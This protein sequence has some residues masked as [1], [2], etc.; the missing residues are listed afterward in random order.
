[1]DNP[2]P[3]SRR[4][5]LKYL[6]AAGAAL[7]L[8]NT[9][10]SETKKMPNILFIITDQHTADVMSC[11]G[12]TDVSTPAIDSLAEHGVRFTRAYVTHPLCIPS[13]AS[14]MTGKM[15]SQCRDNV[16][17]HSTLGTHMKRAGYDTGYFGKWHIQP[18]RETRNNDE[19]HGFDTIDTRGLDPV[20]TENSIAFIKQER[21]Q[22]FFM[23]SSFMNPHDI[24]EWARIHSGREDEMENGDI[25]PAPAP[26]QCPTLPTNFNPPDNEPEM[27]R[28]RLVNNERAR[29]F[30]HPTGDW[31]EDDWRQYR[32][33]YCRLVELVDREVGKLLN[34]LKE[35]GQLEDTLIIYSSDHGDGN[36][37][38]GWNQK[39]VLYEEAVRVPFIVSWKG[40]T[41]AGISS[42]ALVSMNLDLL[43]TCCDFADIKLE[44]ALQGR[45]V[46]DQ[47]M[48][49]SQSAQGHPFVVSET[50]L[51]GDVMGRMLTSGR[52]KYIV[53]SQGENPEQLFDLQND[54]GEMTSL[55]YD[56]KHRNELMRHRTMLSDWTNSIGD[57]FSLDHVN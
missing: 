5:F 36:G 39:V 37:A 12:N 26:S 3:H 22:P 2:N 48:D 4:D 56:P 17:E 46:H 32:W 15:P 54:P 51:F 23:I 34:A 33:A 40:H 21:D 42:D 44:E 6:G 49:N 38:H 50:K 31:K 13:R 9:T 14:F 28:K 57:P 8:P 43:P 24:C 55:A 53:Y 20:K 18:T 45:S 25:G 47:V 27:V 19:W 52:Y 30:A 7:T 35:T 10:W 41:Q 11:A 16:Q 29:T 1:M